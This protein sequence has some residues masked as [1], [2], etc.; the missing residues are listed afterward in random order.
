MLRSMLVSENDVRLFILDRDG[1]KGRED[2]QMNVVA[3][4]TDNL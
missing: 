3:G 1:T 4:V 2:G